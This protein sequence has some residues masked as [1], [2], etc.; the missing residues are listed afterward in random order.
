MKAGTERA[1]ALILAPQ[2]PPQMEPSAPTHSQIMCQTA[3]K[4]VAAVKPRTPETLPAL[5]PSPLGQSNYDALDLEDEE[6][7][8]ASYGSDE[9]DSHG[10]PAAGGFSVGTPTTSIEG[11]NYGFLDEIDGIAHDGLDR[12]STRLNSSHWE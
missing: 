5:P 2:P 9:D 10:S 7:F 3:L 4:D 12:K 6:E 1:R 8:S 11:E